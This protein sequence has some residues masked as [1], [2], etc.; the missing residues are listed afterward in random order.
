MRKNDLQFHTTTSMDLTNIRVKE[1]DIKN[2]Y[3]MI[4]FRETTITS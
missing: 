2:T 1:A 3:S 4:P